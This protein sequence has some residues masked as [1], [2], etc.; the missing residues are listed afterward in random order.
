VIS[1]VVNGEQYIA[2]LAAGTGIPYNPPQGDNLWAFKLGGTAKYTDA[3]GTVVSGSSEAPTPPPLQLRRPTGNTAAST[4][5]P[6]NTILLARSNGT[7]TLPR[8][9]RRR[10]RWFPRH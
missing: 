10:A 2:V 1:Y 9:A 8:T 5:V 4:L 6:A 3:A 7:A